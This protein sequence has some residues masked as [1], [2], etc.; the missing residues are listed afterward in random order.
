MFDEVVW[1]REFVGPISSP[2]G[3]MVI[4]ACHDD[5]QK[6]KGCL[7]KHDSWGFVPHLMQSGG[8][9]MHSGGAVYIVATWHVMAGGVNVPLVW[10]FGF[11]AGFHFF[12]V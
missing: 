11:P 8:A 7:P 3:S 5:H 9:L 12:C 10:L 1:A 2:L 6:V 4:I